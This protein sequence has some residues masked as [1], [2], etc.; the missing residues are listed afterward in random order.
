MLWSTGISYIIA[1]HESGV[2][3][4]PFL[5]EFLAIPMDATHLALT[6]AGTMYRLFLCLSECNPAL[7]LFP[8]G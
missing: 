7:I 2:A 6:L 5:H 1:G 4:T 3:M 8:L